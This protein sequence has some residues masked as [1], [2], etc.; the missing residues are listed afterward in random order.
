ML[1]KEIA[2]VV[3]AALQHELLEQ[4]PAEVEV[5]AV[6][7]E[8]ADLLA[9]AVGDDRGAPAELDVVDVLRAEFDLVGEQAERHAAVD[10]HGQAAGAGLD[11]P[12][13]QGQYCLVHRFPPRE[14]VPNP[15]I[16]TIVALSTGRQVIW[17]TVTPLV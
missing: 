17:S 2:K 7:V 5:D 11:R 12:L 6:A 16:R 8:H 4:R 1:I 14:S 13:G 3:E 15:G 10:H 9:Q